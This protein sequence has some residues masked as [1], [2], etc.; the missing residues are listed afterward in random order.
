MNNSL[1][2]ALAPR[3]ASGLRPAISAAIDIASSSGAVRQLRGETE[4]ERLTPVEHPRRED[5]L[6]GDIGAHQRAEHQRAG[7]V[8][9]QSPVHLAH[10]ELRVGMDDAD[11]GAER[12][13][14]ATAQRVAVHRGDDRNRDL[15]PHP[16]H[17]LAE[18]RDPAVLHLSRIVRRPGRSPLAIIWNDEKSRPAQNDEPSPLNTTTRTPGSVF[19]RSP[20]LGKSLEHRPVERIALLGTI[21]SHVGDTVGDGHA[22]SFGHV[23]SVADRTDRPR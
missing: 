7:H 21:H 11:V 19:S 3:I 15:L 23:A 9:H 5:E 10:A 4:C 6:L 2:N 18:M 16:T 8:G 14:D 17:L 13:L 1:S 20:H 22:H 12:D